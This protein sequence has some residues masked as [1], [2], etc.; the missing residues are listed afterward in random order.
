MIFL[1]I[2]NVTPDMILGKSIVSEK[3]EL[4]LSRGE[5]L[6]LKYIKRIK[7]LG[8]HGIYVVIE[9]TESIAPNESLGDRVD[10]QTNQA[11]RESVEAIQD[12]VDTQK[13]SLDTLRKD[14]RD[15][16][17]RF[18]DAVIAEKIKEAVYGIVEDI[19]LNEDSLINLS[20]LRTKANAF[21][22]MAIDVA[23][24]SVTLGIKFGYNRNELFELATGA[25]L[26]DIGMSVVPKAILEKPNRLTFEE[27]SFYKEHTVFG[28]EI[29][30]NNPQIGL[31]AAHMAYQ[32]HERQDG[33]G[34]PRG[35]KGK[36]L[37]PQK[38]N[39]YEPGAI[40]R[41]AEIVSVANAYVDMITPKSNMMAKEPQDAI[42]MILKLSE[43]HFNKYIV[44]EFVKLL[45]VY[46]VG[47]LFCVE[48]SNESKYNGYKGVVVEVNRNNLAAPLVS[49]IMDASGK[50]LKPPI[51]LDLS[52]SMDV[53]I[54]LVL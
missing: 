3:G 1:P 27:F 47:A 26:H 54:K 21:F 18:R 37:E 2:E 10:M 23:V 50:Y 32:H 40:H 6:N 44:K 35:L 49:L 7:E 36:N 45:P 17:G 12:M 14:F 33:G 41:Y 9:G 5:V 13:E 29:L 11:L 19:L 30:K 48:N 39:E 20:L 38:R 43:N 22:R 51:H 42:K 28:Y 24:I 8:Y 53:S 25:L 4:L 46:P 52:Q 15:G 31:M 34:Y 16:G